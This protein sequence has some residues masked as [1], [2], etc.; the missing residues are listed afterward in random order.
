MKKLIVEQKI[1]PLVNQYR[2]YDA[3]ET[4]AKGN[5]IAFAQQKRLTMKEKVTVYSDE[6]KQT[7]SFTITAEKVLDVHGSFFVDN[8][9]GQRIG[10][11]K[12]AF[13]ASLQRST[14][15]IYDASSTPVITVQE[16]SQAVAIMRRIWDFLPVIGEFI[17]FF[18]RY[19]FDLVNQSGAVV[20][21]YNKT[22]RLL[23]RYELV[24]T[25]DSIIDR[26]GWQTLI[27]QAIMLDVMQGR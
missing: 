27:A 3:L 22:S 21:Q 14:Y 4:G 17:P 23:D 9:E 26:L 13:K 15:V 1:T 7:V 18:V 2:V 5:L 19:H 11:F 16:R 10:L 20:A 25:D 12:K 24:V 6:T 8:A